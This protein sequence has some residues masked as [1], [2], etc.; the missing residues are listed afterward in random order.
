[1]C[2]W[3]MCYR[4]QTIDQTLSGGRSSAATRAISNGQSPSSTL[5]NVARECGTHVIHLNPRLVK[6]FFHLLDPLSPSVSNL[7]IKRLSTAFLDFPQV[8]R[9][10]FCFKSLSGTFSHNLNLVVGKAGLRSLV[11][12]VGLG[13]AAYRL[14]VRLVFC[15]HRCFA[16]LVPIWGG[17]VLNV[18]YLCP[19]SLSYFRVGLGLKCTLLFHGVS[20]I[21][22]PQ[23]GRMLYDAEVSMRRTG[24]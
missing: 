12:A 4:G 14:S 17:T 19:P 15:D 21:D 20:D 7:G 13:C 9:T 6:L 16:C 1:M 11:Q 10:L 2:S 22:G 3:F 8:T 18:V 5:P 24:N 23:R